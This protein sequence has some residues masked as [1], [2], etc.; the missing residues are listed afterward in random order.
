M[1]E[2]VTMS[3]E[4]GCCHHFHSCLREYLL[5]IQSRVFLFC[6]NNVENSLGHKP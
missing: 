1:E 2:F 3:L 4:D 5:Q 6:L